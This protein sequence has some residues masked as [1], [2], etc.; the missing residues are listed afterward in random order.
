M[1]RHATAAAVQNI[2]AGAAGEDI[3]KFVPVK[4]IVVSR[5]DYALDRNELIALRVAAR[6]DRRRKINNYRAR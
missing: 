4:R 1:K 3:V 6:R 2:I 5:A